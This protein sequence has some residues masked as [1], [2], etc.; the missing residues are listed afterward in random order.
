M[1]RQNKAIR[2]IAD[3]REQGIAR[4]AAQLA[5]DPSA[6]EEMQRL[7][8]AFDKG[9]AVVQSALA[10]HQALMDRNVPMT[11]LTLLNQE[12]IGKQSRAALAKNARDRER[13][14][15]YVAEYY[16]LKPPARS[17]ADG[18]RRVK[19]RHA[20]ERLR[21]PGLRQFQQMLARKSAPLE[22]GA[23]SARQTSQP[24]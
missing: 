14:A 18:W 15:R 6:V 22:R 19:Q 17:I 13:N 21:F 24:Q 16:E 8:R 9:L 20:K 5:N 11:V 23:H 10:Q 1:A 12:R 4:L 2:A 3:L 7:L